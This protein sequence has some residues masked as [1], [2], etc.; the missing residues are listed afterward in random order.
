MTP[1]GSWISEPGVIPGEAERRELHRIRMQHL[2]HV[3]HREVDPQTKQ[4][5]YHAFGIT[6]EIHPHTIV[7]SDLAELDERLSEGEN[8]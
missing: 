2:G 4:V 3:I 5:T 7:T 8:G 6:I 1:G